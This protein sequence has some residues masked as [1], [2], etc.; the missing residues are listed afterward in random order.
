MSGPASSPDEARTLPNRN[1]G[2]RLRIALVSS[3]YNYIKDGIAL[4]M[5][6]LVSF[7][8]SRGVDVL[9][10]APV[11]K[12]AAFPHSGTLVPV[13]SVP[14]PFRPEYRVALGLPHEARWRIMAFNPHIIHITVPDLLGYQALRFGRSFGVPVVA[15]YHTRY[16]TYLKYYP[17]LELLRPLL[18]SYLRFFYR[19]CQNVYV[20]SESMAQV[21]ADHGIAENVSLWSRGVDTD[22][23]SPAKRSQLWQQRYGIGDNKPVVIFISRLVREKELATLAAVFN[24]LA[25]GANVPGC[26]VVGDGPERAWLE[27]QI[28][29][30]IFT[31]FLDG[32]DLARAYASS[33]VF[34]FPSETESFGN[35]TLEAMASGLPTVCADATGSR[36]LVVHGETGYLA[37]PRDI[38]G[39]LTH[40]RQLLNDA[41]LRRRLGAAARV[42]SLHY[43]WDKVMQQM[44]ASYR[45]I[46]DQPRP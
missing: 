14:L 35:V 31:G 32:E 25:D 39:F 1:G 3:S 36:S 4:T 38:Q 5:N 16:E 11:S 40:V 42:R 44:L 23:F 7:L 21:L 26:V 29:N 8:E 46:A 37:S 34:F 13:A 33:D 17:G 43:S 10:V 41:N 28:P 22:R 19:S 45:S 9:V 12:T 30:A 27:A 20:P 6:R 15:S 18:K 2:I 24:G